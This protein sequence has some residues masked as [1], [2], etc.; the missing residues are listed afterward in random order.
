[1][2]DRP[3]W[4]VPPFVG[5]C[6]VS[7]CLGVFVAASVAGAMLV[8]PPRARAANPIPALAYYYIWYD[9]SSWRRAK[10]TYPELGRYS[11][12]DVEV[13][14]QHV[15]W[16][17]DAGLNGFIVSWKST[18]TLNRRLATLVRVADSERFK[19]AI[20]YQGLDF[21]RNPLPVER[22]ASDLTFFIS[23]FGWHP[24][25]DLE[26]K[27]IV[28]WSGTWRYT[29]A[30]IRSVARRV[31]DHVLLLASEKSVAGYRR[32]GDFVD[33]DAYYWSSVNPETQPSY[34]DKLNEMSA[35]IHRRRGY[36]IAPA[37]PGFD[38]RLIGGTRVV[39]RRNGSTL[40]REWG[41]AL[42]SAP[43]AVGLISWNEFSENSEVEPTTSFGKTYLDVVK[44]LAG[45]RVAVQGDFDS[46]APPPRKFGYA[47]PLFAGLIAALLMGIAGYV[48]RREV[49]KA[50]ERT[51]ERMSM[52]T[53]A[54]ADARL[55]ST[56]GA[57]ELG[58]RP[59]GHSDDDDPRPT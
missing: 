13:M 10:T 27:P 48:W 32:L 24:A 5:R 44:S 17:R 56:G 1:M 45:G 37:A 41:T 49:K 21:H 22:V 58:E 29:P 40:R 4:S 25:F 26:D 3:V 23:R 9:A 6:L 12:D 8:A 34:G 33:G 57:V 53:L 54:G 35:E 31:R 52:N 28:I 51:A 59:T 15:V 18:P 20:I 11:S 50:L 14:R 2:S 19:L 16:A 39:D 36:W 47:V 43:D 7:S 30:Q 55:G 42:A 46:S 38:A